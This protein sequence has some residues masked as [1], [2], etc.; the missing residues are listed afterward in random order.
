MGKSKNKRKKKNKPRMGSFAAKEK[1]KQ[2]IRKYDDPVLKTVCDPIKDKSELGFLGEMKGVLLATDDGVGLA[3]P[4]I[5]VTKRVFM[6][7]PDIKDNTV[8]ILINPEIVDTSKEL[9]NFQEGCLSYPGVIVDTQRYSYVKVR[10]LTRNMEEKERL[11]TGYESI[12]V[13][14]EID[15]LYGECKNRIEWM[16]I[17]N[18]KEQH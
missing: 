3:A 5:G 10:Y 16:R 2:K 13:Q 6:M 4:Q 14:H 11:F 7:R 8:R 12:I 1:I 15:H 18:I 17:N 9:V